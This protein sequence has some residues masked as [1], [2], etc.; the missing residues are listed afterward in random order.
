MDK[1]N[2]LPEGWGDPSKATNFT[3][4]PTDTNTAGSQQESADNPLLKQQEETVV[5]IEAVGMPK[6]LNLGIIALIVALAVLISVGIFVGMYLGG[7]N[8]GNGNG[9]DLSSGGYTSSEPTIGTSGNEK[10]PTSSPSLEP[11]TTP[12]PSPET[13]PT[14]EP[15]PETS[16]TPEPTPEWQLAYEKVINGDNEA[17]RPYGDG[18]NKTG[19]LVAEAGTDSY[20]NT[21][22]DRLPDDVQVHE[23]ESYSFS[24]VDFDRDGI[25][26]LVIFISGWEWGGYDIYSYQNGNIIYTTDR[27]TGD[28]WGS[29]SVDSV[30][31][32]EN[33]TNRYINIEYS[34]TGEEW[35][36]NTYTFENGQFVPVE[37]QPT[38]D[39]ANDIHIGDS[40]YPIADF[41]DEWEEYVDVDGSRRWQVSKRWSKE[42]F[43]RFDYSNSPDFETAL[44]AYLTN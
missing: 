7:G 2:K 5:P 11:T 3:E 40:V 4:A 34:Y 13:S 26:E 24:L 38:V 30:P 1:N 10:E 44:A 28:S 27:Y 21:N 42:G 14:P 8:E 33:K 37:G 35:W 41:R 19:K 23:M 29:C 17:G 16:L 25:P 15:T 22:W 43:T 9:D 6:K 36:T 18:Y 39:F 20:G 32:L 31:F 12:E